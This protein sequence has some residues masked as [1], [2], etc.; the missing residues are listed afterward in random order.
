M[1]SWVYWTIFVYLA[2]FD[3]IAFNVCVSLDVFNNICVFSDILEDI[4]SVLDNI[5]RSWQGNPPMDPWLAQGQ[6]FITINIIVIDLPHCGYICNIYFCKAPHYTKTLEICPF[7]CAKFWTINGASVK[8]W[9]IW[10][11]HN[12]HTLWIKTLQA[13]EKVFIASQ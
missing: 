7:L 8:K 4:L 12:C 5:S 9:Q 13:D 11:P 6:H 1:I 3:N 2:G 10:G